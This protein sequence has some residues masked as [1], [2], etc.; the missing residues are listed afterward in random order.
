MEH[1]SGRKLLECRS[2]IKNST[3][4]RMTFSLR[5][6]RAMIHARSGTKFSRESWCDSSPLKNFIV[7]PR[8]VAGIGG[9][10][11]DAYIFPKNVVRA[12]PYREEEA[13]SRV[14]SCSRNMGHSRSKEVRDAYGQLA[15]AG[16]R[17][18]VRTAVGRYI[19]GPTPAR[20]SE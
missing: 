17:P 9:V 6:L 8:R 5:D 3:T 14:H 2:N 7:V 1:L 20:A 18:S 13:R 4:F 11:R 10:H 19:T 12:R 15:N 16:Q